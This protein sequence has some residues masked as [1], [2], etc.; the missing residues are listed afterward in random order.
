MNT[1]EPQ[2]SRHSA[3]FYAVM[4]G[5]LAVVATLIGLSLTTGLPGLHNTPTTNVAGQSVVGKTASD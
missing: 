1:P 5:G 3:G 4:I 2:T